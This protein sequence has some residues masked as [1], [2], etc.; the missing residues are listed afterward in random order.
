MTWQT[1]VLTSQSPLWPAAIAG[2]AL[3]RDVA[4]SLAPVVDSPGKRWVFALDEHG[5]PIGFA[6]LTLGTPH[7]LGSAYVLPDR[8]RCGVY[9][10]LVEA[11][12]LLVGQERITATCT[13]T[14]SALLERYG[15]RPVRR[16]GKFTTMEKP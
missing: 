1:L 6:A 8:R 11:R 13:P 5:V 12:L 16:R 4:R 10:A 15:F 7:T 14:T 2:L 9:T 3:R